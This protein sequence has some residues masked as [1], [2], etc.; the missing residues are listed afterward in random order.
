MIALL[1]Q[2]ADAGTGEGGLGRCGSTAS[3]SA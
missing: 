2:V 1:R 3:D